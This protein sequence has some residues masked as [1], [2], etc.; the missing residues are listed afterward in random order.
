MC[1][2]GSEAGHRHNAA[3]VSRPHMQMPGL[4]A[5]GCHAEPRRTTNMSL[6]RGTTLVG[7]HSMTLLK[8]PPPLSLRRGP[9]FLSVTILLGLV[10]DHSVLGP[11]RSRA[12]RRLLRKRRVAVVSQAC[13]NLITKIV[14]GGAL[15]FC[16]DSLPIEVLY[17]D[18]VPTHVRFREVAI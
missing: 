2:Q 14:C 15:T 13:W 10:V 1:A 18:M 6:S 11:A 4:P 8:L 12:S 7:Q 16:E 17:H 9:V 5:P 3:P